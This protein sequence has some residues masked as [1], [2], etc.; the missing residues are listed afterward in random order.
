MTVSSRS[1]TPTPASTIPNPTATYPQ[2]STTA[3]A[4]SPPSAAGRHTSPWRGDVA[5][6]SVFTAASASTTVVARF[7]N[8][9][10]RP[11]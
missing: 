7:S 1:N 3:V 6:A 10:G 9:S 2:G 5:V 8:A 4:A 11:V